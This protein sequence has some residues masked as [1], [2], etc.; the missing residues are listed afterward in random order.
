MHLHHHIQRPNRGQPYGQAIRSFPLDFA[1]VRVRRDP[2]ILVNTGAGFVV[3]W[4]LASGPWPAAASAAIGA[5]RGFHHA[6]LAPGATWPMHIH[7]DLQSVTYVVTGVLEHSDSLGNHG[8]LTAGGVQQRWLGWGAEHEER[9]PSATERTEFIQLW[10]WT[11]QPDTTALEQHTQYAPDDRFERW[12][13]IFRSACSA[14]DGLT[15][16]QDARVQVVRVDSSSGRLEY[17]FEAGHGGYVYMIDGDAEAN[18]ERLQT[19]DAA[20]VTAEGRLHIRA[21]SATELLIVD[22]PV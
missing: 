4:H 7:E 13:Q 22:V 14:R 3:R 5:L 11:P 6:I 18:L 2:E 12:L 19:G 16:T 15:V 17:E 10:L 8:L 20:H 1:P 9:N 21:F